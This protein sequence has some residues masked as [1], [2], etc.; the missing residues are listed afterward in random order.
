MIVTRFAPT[1]SGELHVGGLYNALL[2]YLFA[3]QN[4]GQFKVRFD[5][6]MNQQRTRWCASMLESLK[7]CNIEVD[8]VY[9]S[10]KHTEEHREAFEHLMG[11]HLDRFYACDCSPSDVAQRNLFGFPSNTWVNLIFRPEKYPPPC[12]VQQIVL[13]D[14]SGVIIFGE[15]I[16][17][18]A[19][20]R[21]SFSHPEHP[22]ENIQSSNTS[23]WDPYVRGTGNAET[24]PE[25]FIEFEEEV[26]IAQIQLKWH[27]Y[28][29]LGGIVRV[30]YEGQW[31]NVYQFQKGPVFFTETRPSVPYET[32]TIDSIN[33]A[34][35]K[36]KA[37]AFRF[38]KF[39][40]PLI[41]S[42]H[43]DGYC[44]DRNKQLDLDDMGTNIRITY[45]D[46]VG[47]W[48]Q[49]PWND[50][51]IPGQFEPKVDT[52]VWFN[53]QPDLVFTSPYDD[54]K[55][56]VTHAIR[57]IDIYPFFWIEAPVAALLGGGVHSQFF[58]SMVVTPHNVKY[59]KFIKSPCIDRYLDQGLSAEMLL[60][61]LC[62]RSGI[63]EGEEILNVSELVEAVDLTKITK[64]DIV[65]A[66]E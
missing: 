26:E 47:E 23:F 13:H 1:A 7:R 28:P 36:V 48:N 33:I 9:Y 30:L 24:A 51:R 60:T 38:D 14:A 20:V 29:V 35:V 57:G 64:Q 22:I 8:E 59:S 46:I 15:D 52:C 56:G 65:F 61:A 12:R 50:E 66:D 3:R 43:Y 6:R 5:G 34:P 42:Y 4:E 17:V 19:T 49:K 63:Y 2:N 11:H 25:I 40:Q 31:K 32:G 58:H 55:L 44:R 10:H 21:A 16:K 62:Q 37:I 54:M 45:Q 53:G 27:D 41:K 39:A 18:D